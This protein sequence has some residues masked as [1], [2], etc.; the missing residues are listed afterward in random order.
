MLAAQVMRGRHDCP[1]RSLKYFA[2]DSKGGVSGGTV[3]TGLY[4]LKGETLVNDW[5]Y[6]L[7]PP[8]GVGGPDT[9]DGAPSPV[10]YDSNAKM[11]H[12]P[13]IMANI[14]A[15][16]VRR[17]NALLG[18]K[19]GKRCSYSEVSACSSFSAAVATAASLG[20]VG[21]VA[22]T[23][24]T[25]L[26]SGF[27][28]QPGDG[29]D[30]ATRDTGYFNSFTV[31]IGESEKNPVVTARMGSGSAGDPGYKAT[32]QMCIEAAL[33]LACDSEQL[34]SVGGGVLTPAVAIG[35]ALVDRLVTSGMTFSVDADSEPRL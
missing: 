5:P 11:W 29:P 21:L 25:N 3:H 34:P 33:C 20:S 30:K 9:R 6:I 4:H 32:A 1:C 26:F 16:V 22:A 14:N 7:D 13:F 2:A 35:Q 24:L 8:N 27:L 17:S 10:A 15:K 31:A 12:A 19:Y 23:P 28:P 18:Y